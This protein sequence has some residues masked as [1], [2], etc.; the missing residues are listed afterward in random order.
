LFDNNPA[1]SRGLP[2]DFNATYGIP[3]SGLR[4]AL[5]KDNSNNHDTADSHPLL[6][7]KGHAET[8]IIYAA[9][10]PENP[11]IP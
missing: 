4:N 11:K 1:F 10:S 9:T 3:T 8:Y 6:F 2:V 7:Q 5:Q